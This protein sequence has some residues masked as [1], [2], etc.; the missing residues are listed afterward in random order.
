MIRYACSFQNKGWEV[1]WR[2]Q[3]GNKIGGK[4]L[5]EGDGFMGSIIPFFLPLCMYAN[6]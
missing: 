3:K 2:G 5:T 4:F 6:P 1:S